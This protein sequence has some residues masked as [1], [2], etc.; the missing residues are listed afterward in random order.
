MG[1]PYS[2]ESRQK[3]IQCVL[4]G[5]A[6]GI[7]LAVICRA[8]G[9][10]DDDTIRIWADADP[11]LSRSIARAREAGFDQIALDALQI[12]DTEPEIAIGA[13]GSSRRDP[14]YVAWQKARF[15]GRLKLLA[16]WDPKRYG[17]LLK[18]GNADGS[19]LDLTTRLSEARERAVRGE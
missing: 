10:P 9:M 19:N 12:M 8:E 5:L 3:A 14:A 16:K 1:A 4:D 11:E 7:P 15:D 13:D 2:P 17:E 6:K 18:H